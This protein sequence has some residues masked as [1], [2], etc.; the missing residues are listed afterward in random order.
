[1]AFNVADP[2]EQPSKRYLKILVVDDDDLNRR[3]MRL[4]LVRRWA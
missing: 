3:M 2:I 4:I 1:M